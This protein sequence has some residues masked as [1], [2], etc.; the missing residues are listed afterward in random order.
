M[1]FFYI[2]WGTT[3]QSFVNETPE[4]ISVSVEYS[5]WKECLK[6]HESFFSIEVIIVNISTFLKTVEIVCSNLLLG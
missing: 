6:K 3:E 5:P 2:K 1:V 4:E